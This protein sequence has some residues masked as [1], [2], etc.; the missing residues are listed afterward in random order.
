M[1]KIC[2]KCGALKRLD[3]FAFK[4]K[5]RGVRQWSCRA[6]NAAYKLRW[7]ERNRERHGHKVRVV[8][9]NSSSN[10]RARVWSYLAQHPCVDCGETDPVVLEFDHLRDKR[11]SIGYMCTAGFAWSTIELEIEKCDV[12]CANCHRRRTARAQGIY[13]AKHTPRLLE[14]PGLYRVF[15]NQSARAVSSADRAPVF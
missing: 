11:E 8:R 3:E 14:G 13:E 10:N 2:P 5:D 4:Y 9:A 1:E 6:C 7:Y 15:D 12:R